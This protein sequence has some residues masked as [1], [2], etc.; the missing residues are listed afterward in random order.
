MFTI[1]E[2]KSLLK[3]GEK[4]NLECKEA[5]SQV[6]KSIF[7]TYSA[8]ANTNGGTI[9]LGIHE[10]LKEPDPEKHFTITGV[11]DTNKIITDF[12]NTING[13]KVNVNLLI[14]ED[15]YP[16]DFEGTPIVIIE[17]PRASYLLRPVYTGENP[18]KGSI[19]RNHEGDYH[20][21]ETEIRAMYRDQ[22]PDGNDSLIMEYY[23]MEDIDADTLKRYRRLFRTILH[24]VQPETRY[25]AVG[26]HVILYPYRRRKMFPSM[27]CRFL[28]HYR[29][30]NRRKNCKS[31]T[32]RR[33]EYGL[34]Y[35]FL[36]HSDK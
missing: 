20:C 3:N 9:L 31:H 13:N 30:G 15:V 24:A 7:E 10:N 17:V 29:S 35:S 26:P 19:K 4:V 33:S 21:S 5:E 27:F 11:S 12:W 34:R 23:T 14:D 25:S 22:N 28:P 16:F 2:I 6:P 18:F 36:V 1:D 8:F 32:L